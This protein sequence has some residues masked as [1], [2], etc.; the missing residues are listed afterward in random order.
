MLIDA[1]FTPGLL[2][3]AVTTIDKLICAYSGPRQQRHA[4]AFSPVLLGAASAYGPAYFLVIS[5]L[6]CIDNPLP[7]PTTIRNSP[8]QFQ[9]RH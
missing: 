8:G 2:A 1:R 3:V 6:A 9:M 4:L 7:M 5:A